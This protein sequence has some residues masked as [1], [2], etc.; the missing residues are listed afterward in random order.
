MVLI[1]FFIFTNEFDETLKNPWPLCYAHQTLS[2][3]LIRNNP[4]PLYRLSWTHGRLLLYGVVNMITC[5]W[6]FIADVEKFYN[7]CVNRL[8]NSSIWNGNWIFIVF[9]RFI[10]TILFYSNETCL[11]CNFELL[12]YFILILIKHSY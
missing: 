4:Y 1:S 8:E 2:L 10:K 12:F 5:A 3:I 11:S 9:L 6:L 7:F